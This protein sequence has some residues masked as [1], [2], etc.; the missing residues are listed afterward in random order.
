LLI[1]NADKGIVVCGSGVGIGIA[2]VKSGISCSTCF[3]EYM[4]E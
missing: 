3:N 2:M 1:K 4:A